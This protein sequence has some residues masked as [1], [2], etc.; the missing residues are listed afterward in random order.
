MWRD[1]CEC[2]LFPTWFSALIGFWAAA[3]GSGRA[4]R[5]AAPG[6]RGRAP[7]RFRPPRE[8]LRATLVELTVPAD[9]VAQEGE[10]LDAVARQPRG[11]LL[12]YAVELPGPPAQKR[13]QLDQHLAPIGAVGRPP[14][15][16]TLLKSIEHRSHGARAQPQRG[17]QGACRHRPALIDD[18]HTA[19]IGRV[20][21]QP[22]GDRLVQR[23]DRGLPAADLTPQLD[24]QLVSWQLL[25]SIGLSEMIK[26]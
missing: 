7:S 23:G 14:D 4:V 17:G 6:P 5:S 8:L 2:P 10:L 1:R 13:R 15:I 22:L 21:S 18:V 19:V 20:D 12:S 9:E 25:R 24:A 11:D 16:V 26:Y 3:R